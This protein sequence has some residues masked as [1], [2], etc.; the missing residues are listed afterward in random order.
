MPQPT[1]LKLA[2]AKRK[3][4]LAAAYR[5]FSRHSFAA[6]S[7]TNLVK[8]LGIAKGSVYQYFTDKEDLHQYLV[9]EANAKLGHLLDKACAY[10]DEEFFTWY[11]KLVMVE[12]KF[13]LSFPQYGMLFQQLNTETSPAQKRL[14]RQIETAR[15]ERIAAQLPAALHNSPINNLLLVRSPLLIFAMLIRDLDVQQIIGNDEAV[16]LEAGELVALC[17][18][19]V[20]KLRQGL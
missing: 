5:E 8:T 17:T 16:Y 14:A 11:S 12:V 13:Y 19:W 4:F 7:I 6:A 1:F 18:T 10:N 9:T 15:L 20:K 3:Q 2:E